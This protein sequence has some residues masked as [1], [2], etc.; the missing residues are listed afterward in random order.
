MMTS[1]RKI[2]I[3]SSVAPAISLAVLL[4]FPLFVDGSSTD[5][6]GVAIRHA[7]IRMSLKQTPDKLGSWLSVS[8]VEIPSGALDIL[9]PNAYLSRK[10]QRIGPGRSLFATLMIIH[11]R[12]ARDMSGHYPPV[13][14]PRG[15][16]LHES[17]DVW[18]G[19]IERPDAFDLN[20]RIYK[21]S[22]IGPDGIQRTIM[23]ADSFILPRGKSTPKMSEVLK[24]AGRARRSAQGVA[25][26]QIYLEG[27]VPIENAR[28]VVDEILEALPASLLG[29]LVDKGE[30]ALSET[31]EGTSHE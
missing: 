24:S 14:Y 31:G 12:D 17:G 30:N 13:C 20:Y 3:F 4:I 26:I 22:R 10:Y 28:D 21:F 2:S 5:Q 27:D 11:C 9:R 18:N 16:W 29:I 1:N 25:Q 15:G 19:K 6:V 8:D 23:V 7:E